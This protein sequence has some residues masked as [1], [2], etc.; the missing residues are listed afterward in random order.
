MNY[1]PENLRRWS[2]PDS[3]MGASWPEYFVFL[4]Q[5]RD[6][7]TLTRSNFLAGLAAI[8]GESD[9][10]QIIRE[11]HWAVGWLEWIAIHESD[12]K[13]LREADEIAGAL[14]DYPVVSDEHFSELEWSEACEYW[15][16]LSV[17]ERAEF[18]RD[19]R[20]GASV[21]AARR[22]ELPQDDNGALQ[23]RLNG[24]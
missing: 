12:A 20:C 3:Y 16:R 15:E 11:G 14:T 17:R 6:S 19:S 18:I 1:Q 2:L 9:T 24:Y 21:F 5:H 13:A 4:A 7:D 23:Q 10:V 8:G 22:D